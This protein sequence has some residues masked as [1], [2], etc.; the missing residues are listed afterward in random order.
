LMLAAT[1]EHL[2][3]ETVLTRV[4]FCLFGEDALAEFQRALAELTE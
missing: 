3:G 1:I 4:V 2:R